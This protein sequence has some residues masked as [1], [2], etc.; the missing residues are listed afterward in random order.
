MGLKEKKLFLELYGLLRVILGA[1]QLVGLSAGYFLNEFVIHY[2]PTVIPH[3]M[4]QDIVT[5]V[6]LAVVLK[7]VFHITAGIGISRLKLWGKILL[8]WGWPVVGLITFGSIFTF[9]Q[10]WFAEGQ[11]ASFIEII[12]WPKLIIY[13]GFIIFDLAFI[14]PMISEIN[15]HEDFVLK[16]GGR[17]EFKKIAFTFFITILGLC[18]ILFLGRPIKQGFHQGFYKSRGEKNVSGQFHTV[19]ETQSSS[20]QEEEIIPKNKDTAQGNVILKPAQPVSVKMSE[21]LTPKKTLEDLG[22]MGENKPTQTMPY[23]MMTGVLGGIC[24]IIGFILQM[25]GT[26]SSQK[27]ELSRLSYVVLGVGFLL[28]L[29]FGMSVKLMPISLTSFVVLIICVMIIF[30]KVN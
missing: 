14:N 7:V 11:V 24:I 1:G 6:C 4:D 9:Y 25:M 22:R 27:S 12:Q 26:G 21:T 16:S 23:R 30:T 13:F 17:L 18:V 10:E 19:L 2:P 15:L 3:L 28:W 29:T 8:S 5:V 20:H